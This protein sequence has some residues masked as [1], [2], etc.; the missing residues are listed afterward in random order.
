VALLLG[1]VVLAP[2]GGCGRVSAIDSDAGAP[3]GAACDG[4]SGTGDGTG[5]GGG[6][7]GCVTS[8]A[9]GAG[10]LCDGR[11][12]DLSSDHEAC[13]RCGNACDADAL[14]SQGACTPR[15]QAPLVACGAHCADLSHDPHHC[16][17]CA[18]DCG[19]S[20]VCGSG[21]C[22]PICPLAAPSSIG[23]GNLGVAVGDVDGDGVLDVVGVTT[24]NGDSKLHVY[25][26]AAHG[27]FH[28][29]APQ[30]LPIRSL[31]VA[32]ADLNGDHRL[33]AAL[34]TGSGDLSLSVYLNQG[35]GQFA[36]AGDFPA[37]VWSSDVTLADVDGDGAPDAVIANSG[38]SQWNGTITGND[39]TVL[40]NDGHASFGRPLHMQGGIQPSTVV[41]ADLD[42]DGAPDIAE[43]DIGDGVSGGAVNLYFGDGHGGFSAASPIAPLAT[44]GAL[45]VADLDGNASADLAV[46]GWESVYVLLHGGGRTFGPPVAYAAPSPGGIATGDMNGDGLPDLVMGGASIAVLFNLGHGTFEAAAACAPPDGGSSF[47]ASSVV[48]ADLAS[49]GRS[50]VVTDDASQTG[51]DVW[52]WWAQPSP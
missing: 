15:C 5:D 36:A 38:G 19:G 33:D 47:A 23:P 10:T 25:L 8:C 7:G 16:G 46:A 28:A 30:P 50:D 21:A 18:N 49:D 1:G 45:A 35:G 43:S 24:L 44:N 4:G 12:V 17:S 52:V 51:G 31:G 39:V 3:G 2:L 11:C 42:G 37:G 41:V 48:V 29:L 32:L 40:F 14:C 27:A 13:G 34:L 6:S 22:T 20:H 9:G 26:G